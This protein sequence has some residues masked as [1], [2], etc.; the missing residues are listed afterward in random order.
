MRYVGVLYE[1]SSW[2]LT[3]TLWYA[4]LGSSSLLVVYIAVLLADRVGLKERTYKSWS[5][6][7]RNGPIKS[8]TLMLTLPHYLAV[9]RSTCEASTSILSEIKNPCRHRCP[10]LCPIPQFHLFHRFS[11]LVIFCSRCVI[12]CTLLFTVFCKLYLLYK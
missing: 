3:Q 1:Y 4:L 5:R 9:T 8:K 2:S 6:M 12:L 11:Q 7:I 10:R